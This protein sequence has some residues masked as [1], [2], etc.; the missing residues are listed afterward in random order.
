MCIVAQS[1]VN[2]RHSVRMLK[3]KEKKHEIHREN[4]STLGRSSPI[5]LEINT[6]KLGMSLKVFFCEAVQAHIIVIKPL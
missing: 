3:G 5:H 6:M 1:K 4:Q 2:V